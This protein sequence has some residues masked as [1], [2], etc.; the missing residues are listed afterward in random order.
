MS[1]L[2]KKQAMQDAPPMVRR[3]SSIFGQLIRSVNRTPTATRQS[4]MY[5]LDEYR[6]RCVIWLSQQPEDHVLHPIYQAIEENDPYLKDVVEVVS[7]DD[8]PEVIAAMD[9]LVR[10][11]LEEQKEK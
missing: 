10:Y 4:L 1:L 7:F 5:C 2:V 9:V 11:C 6:V 8:P 3:K